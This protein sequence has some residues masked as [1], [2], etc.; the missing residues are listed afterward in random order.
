MRND[1]ISWRRSTSKQK[2]K[3]QQYGGTRFYFS[4]KKK[5]REFFYYDIKLNKE[6]KKKETLQLN[7]LTK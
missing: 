3:L 4:E 6:A 7:E 1:M 5:R 2:R